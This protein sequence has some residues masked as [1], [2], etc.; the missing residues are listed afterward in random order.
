MNLNESRFFNLNDEKNDV[1]FFKLN[2]SWWSRFYEYAW[3]SKFINSDDISLDAASGISH[4][5]KFYLLDRCKETH[6]LDCDPRILKE[7]KIKE[8]II[9][10]FGKEAVLKMEDKYFKTINY[11][12]ATLTKMP[13]EDK[14]FDKIYC[15][16]VL[17]H[18]N[19]WQ[20]KLSRLN[21]FPWLKKFKFDKFRQTLKE[22]RR[23]LKDN[24]LIILTFDYPTID[25]N[26]FK[27]I[28]AEL[29]LK[30][31]DNVDFTIPQNAVYS[32]ENKLF[33]FRAVLIKNN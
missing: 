7:E 6:A 2:P 33:C 30:F 10:D 5:F 31:V 14:K 19:D 24:G 18:L 15:L 8:D 3:A 1:F 23:V 29:G 28:V 17:E 20:G 26:H 25:L 16:S 4:P 32:K 22:F 13:Y 12:K 21:Q 9:N 11:T 27:K